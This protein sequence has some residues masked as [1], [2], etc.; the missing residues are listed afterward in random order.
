MSYFS[1]TEEHA[2][3][4]L[5]EDLEA[6][7]V[8]DLNE[9]HRQ[10]ADKIFGILS[11]SNSITF[12]D[13]GILL[14]R[15]LFQGGD[16]KRFTFTVNGQTVCDIDQSK[17]KEL[18]KQ[19]E[20]AERRHLAEI[21]KLAN[22]DLKQAQEKYNNAPEGSE[23]ENVAWGAVEKAEK[24]LQQAEVNFKNYKPTVTLKD[25]FDEIKTQINGKNIDEASVRKLA[26]FLA[27]GISV[28]PPTDQAGRG[29]CNMNR[30]HCSCTV[31]EDD[32]LTINQKFDKVKSNQEKELASR[33]R[34][35][36]A[37][38]QSVGKKCYTET[39]MEIERTYDLFTSG[40]RSPKTA[41]LKSLDH[42]VKFED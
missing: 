21:L 41:E 30:C 20:P 28:M 2:K 26:L 39:T 32:T 34:K 36:T 8:G 18:A 29:I 22:N 35:A 9:Q 40:S 37:D 10:N 42:S 14:F 6:G 33:F 23:E 1:V 4:L 7:K 11:K 27:S 19:K 31:S 15:E 24:K 3:T 16:G 5:Q 17:L 13:N 25:F 12:G 38:F